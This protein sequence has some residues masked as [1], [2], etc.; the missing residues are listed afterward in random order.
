MKRHSKLKLS[1]FFFTLFITNISFG[2][3]SMGT[4]QELFNRFVLNT[5]AFKTFQANL[6]SSEN[7]KDVPLASKDFYKP[8]CESSLSIENLFPAL[9]DLIELWSPEN[10]PTVDPAYALNNL[11]VSMNLEK[12]KHDATKPSC[13]TIKISTEKK[14]TAEK[15]TSKPKK[16][17]GIRKNQS[18]NKNIKKNYGYRIY[19]GGLP[20]SLLKLAREEAAKN[21]QKSN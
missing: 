6:P 20:F 8:A 18:R 9:S 12:S 21:S 10:T 1:L 11:I 7:S 2:M 17:R 13:D 4:H 16:P 5:Y 19:T 14:L 3:D 15:E